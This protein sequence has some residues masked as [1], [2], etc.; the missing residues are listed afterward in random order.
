MSDEVDDDIIAP[1]INKKEEKNEETK[2]KDSEEEKEENKNSEKNNKKKIEYYNP[3]IISKN[4]LSGKV[5]FVFFIQ[6][7]IIFLFIY[8]AFHN[9]TFTNLLQKN[10]KFFYVSVILASAIMVASGMVKL[11]SVVPFN[12]FFFFIFSLC[13]SII[14]CKLAI[15]FSFKTIAIFWTL[16]VC[17]IL[18]LSLYALRM[19][20]EIKLIST[21]FF[22]FVILLLV[23]LI[24]KFIANIPI[25]DMLLI[26][27]CLI[28]FNIY[29]IYDVNSLIEEKGIS[30]RDYFTLNILLYLDIIM[31]FIKLVNFIYKNLQTD[32][33]DETLDKV[34]VFT[35]DLEKGID[36]VK[37][38]GKE[39]KEEEDEKD[40]DD[41]EEDKKKKKGKKGKKEEKK[42]KKEDK[43]GKKDD[44]KGKKE[45][46]KGKNK[47]KKKKEA[48]DDEGGDII[49]DVIGGLFG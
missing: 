4:K 15:L 21:S 13:I 12:Y 29:L 3:K 39:K 45:E 16:L 30:S 43:K 23:G 25:V 7:L 34:K 35:E 26:I 31:N 27:L 14:I 44:K 22:V 28:A 41:D 32:E 24:V 17:M 9:E 42:G 38:F 19:K 47:K 8:Y 20:R 11:F 37:N 46:K 10:H 40:E 18:S 2:S 5:Y 1:L 48:D 49:K 6:S 33:K 36:A